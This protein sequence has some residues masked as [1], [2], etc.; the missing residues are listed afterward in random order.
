VC[1]VNMIEQSGG[2]VGCH[3]HC[4]NNLFMVGCFE[5]RCDQ[6]HRENAFLGCIVYVIVVYTAF[7]ASTLL[8]GRQEGHPACKKLRW[9]AG[10]VIC[11][12]GG[13]DLHMAQLMPL[14]LTICCC[15]K[16][17]L[18]LPVW[19]CFWCRLTQVSWKKD[20]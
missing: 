1:L 4:Y 14:P 2:D 8:V 13:A 6:T 11:P 3:Y 7:S 17:R 19:F 20:H 15:S 12:C 5:V 9:G 18:V 10:M 16:S